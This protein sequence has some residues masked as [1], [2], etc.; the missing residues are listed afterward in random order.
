M[1]RSI[2]RVWV[3]CEMR[4]A[5]VRTVICETGCEKHCDWSE[6]RNNLSADP[7]PKP[8]RMP[9]PNRKLLRI[10]FLHFSAFRSLFGKLAF[11]LS[12]FAFRRL[13]IAASSRYTCT[14][15]YAVVGLV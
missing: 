13:P 12:R 7:S 14:T 1:D 5:K 2:I 10:L 11:A 9:T 8:N 15:V 4:N 3:I 6:S